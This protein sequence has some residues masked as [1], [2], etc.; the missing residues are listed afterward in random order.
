MGSIH[1]VRI[2]PN[3]NNTFRYICKKTEETGYPIVDVR[4]QNSQFT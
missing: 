3:T 4:K 1:Q 2:P